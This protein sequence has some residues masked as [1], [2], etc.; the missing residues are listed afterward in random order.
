MKTFSPR[1]RFRFRFLRF[2]IF[3]VLL[4]A[5]ISLVSCSAGSADDGFVVR[6]ALSGNPSTLDPQATTETLTF[7]VTKSLYDTLLEPDDRGALVPALAER[8][9]VAADNLSITF[10]LRKDVSFHD[11]SRLDSSDVRAS[12]ARLQSAAFASP[13]AGEFGVIE[14]VEVLDDFTV[15][16]IL[17]EPSAPLLYTL[18][19]GWSAIL[20]SEL[21]EAG[22][23]FANEPVGT[24]PYRLTEWKA[25]EYIELVRNDAYWSDAGPDG[26]SFR[27]ISEP[28]VQTQALLS[29]Q[30]DILY[31]VNEEDVPILEASGEVSIETLDSAL[32][33]V[34]SINTSRDILGDLRM[35]QALNRAIDKQQ[36]LDVA[37]G[38]G[39]VIGTFNDV[40]SSFYEDYSDLYTYDPAAARQLASQAGYSP[41]RVFDLVLPQNFAPHVTAGELYQEMLRNA[42]I[43]AQIRLVDWS[44]W[45]D[46]V[47]GNANYDLTVI[48]H[49]GKLDPDGRFIGYGSGDMYV[50]YENPELASLIVEGRRTIS[51]PRRREIYRDVQRIFA[52]NVPFVFVGS[53]QRRI[54]MRS[55]IDGFIMTPNLD[56]F[57]FRG[58][59]RNEE[60]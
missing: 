60:N 32:V 55:D 3:A 9:E 34:M 19:S 18:A 7:Q 10:Y 16:L 47:Y 50:R 37:Y 26:V 36:A 4:L 41:D 42:G 15:R 28:S 30:V 35:R 27:I 21:I 12:L 43:N 53:P 14:S 29:D 23:D 25:D 39:T 24:G 57:D 1:F 6:L 33:L 13:S 59:T 8:W 2:P 56:T 49:T 31:I 48:G 11:G 44:T 46:D 51:I 22:H 38:G 5:A 54:A 45:L 52:E 40:T 17:N 20:P 58:V